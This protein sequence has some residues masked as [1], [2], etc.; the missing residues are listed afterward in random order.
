MSRTA[1]LVQIAKEKLEVIGEMNIFEV[2]VQAASRRDL[3]SIVFIGGNALV[4]ACVMAFAQHLP[5]ELFPEH[6]WALITYDFAQH[7]R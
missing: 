3:E 6:I 5:L 1:Y 7:V 2:K 4:D